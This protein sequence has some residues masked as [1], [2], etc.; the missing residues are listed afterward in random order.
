MYRNVRLMLDWNSMLTISATLKS[1]T[2][3]I[4]VFPKVSNLQRSCFFKKNT[5]IKKRGKK[6]TLS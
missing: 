4:L 6:R 2:V 5:I 1:A 3:D